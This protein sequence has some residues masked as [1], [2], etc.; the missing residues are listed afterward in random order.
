MPGTYYD[1]KV[2]AIQHWE[3]GVNWG[4]THQ[5]REKT[6]R[7]RKCLYAAGGYEKATGG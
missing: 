6:L 5:N 1:P 3:S 7:D 4:H 2:E